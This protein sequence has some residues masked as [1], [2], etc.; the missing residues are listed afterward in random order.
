MKIAFTGPECSGKTTLSSWLASQLN[1]AFVAEFARDFL[2]EIGNNYAVQDLDKIAQGQNLNELN[3]ELSGS[4]NIVCDSDLLVI[5]I[6]SEIVYGS[7]SPIIQ[8]LYSNAKYD[9]VFLC[10]PDFAW[11]YDPLRQ[12]PDDEKRMGLYLRYEKQLIERMADFVM[13]EGSIET[14][15]ALI[16]NTLL[17]R[18]YPI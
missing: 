4:A 7:V 2:A 18:G 8:E 16:K 6:W 15:K 1:A 12:Y 9:L 17:Q 11:E 13:L 14:R 5:K 3:A 10:K